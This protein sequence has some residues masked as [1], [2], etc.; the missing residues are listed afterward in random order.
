MKYRPRRTHRIKNGNLHWIELWSLVNTR[1][2][3][4]ATIRT[5]EDQVG[6]RRA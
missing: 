4:A 5:I 3:L 1:V 2:G 6:L